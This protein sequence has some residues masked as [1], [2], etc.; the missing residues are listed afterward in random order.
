MA[1]G[2]HNPQLFRVLAIGEDVSLLS[3]RANL[4][5]Q[6]GYTADLIPDAA[7]ALRRVADR[8]YH[9]AI[10]SHTM[11]AEEEFSLRRKLKQLRPKL[12]VLVAGPDNGAPDDFL[13]EVARS[14]HRKSHFHFGE[15]YQSLILHETE[16]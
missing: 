12:P 5:A 7:I 11:G 10:L 16:T 2:K 4:L 8:N 3:S 13:A 15:R 14:L 1:S 6:A 9:L